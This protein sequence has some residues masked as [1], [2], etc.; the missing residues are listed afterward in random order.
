[1]SVRKPVPAAY[2]IT[3]SRSARTSRASVSV[4]DTLSI[5]ILALSV[6]V[7]STYAFKGPFWAW[8]SENFAPGEAAVVLAH[9]NAI[10]GL[11]SFLG[12]WLF[13]VVKGTTGS[14]ALGLMPIVAFMESRR[15]W[16]L[17]SR[18]GRVSGRQRECSLRCRGFAAQMRQARESIMSSHALC[19]RTSELKV[20]QTLTQRNPA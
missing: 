20:S 11:G 6:A 5:T 17:V 7:M 18:V 1:M 13:G 16:R 3:A 2:P 4:I 12:S 9:V 19:S 8:A 14:Y 10:G 15:S